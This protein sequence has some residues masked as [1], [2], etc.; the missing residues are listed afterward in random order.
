M[1]TIPQ[2]AELLKNLF[3]LLAQQRAMA[4]QQRVYERLEM[5]VLSELFTFGRHTITQLLMSLGL[6]EQDWSGWYRLFSEERFN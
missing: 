3:G 4:D 2:N 1:A 5:L 6:N